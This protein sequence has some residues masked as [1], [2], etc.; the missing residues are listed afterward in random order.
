MIGDIWPMLQETLYMFAYLGIELS[1]LFLAISYVVGVIN[2]Y[3]PARKVQSLMSARSGRGYCFAAALGA[4]TP[5]CSCS[6]I[7][8]LNGLLKAQAG[9]GPIMTFVL[10]SPLL[11]PMIVGLLAATFGVTITAVYSV[12]T[13]MVA[14]LA[15]FLL[16][17][18]GFAKHMRL[19]TSP[20]SCCEQPK[21][22]EDSTP[23]PKSVA[24]VGEPFAMAPLM[25][26][27]C[28][29]EQFDT[30]IEASSCCGAVVS[31][32]KASTWR[33]IAKDSWSQFMHV[34][35]FLLLGVFIGA[36]T[37]GFVP[38]ETITKYAGGGSFW[39]IPIAA[40][41]GIPLYLRAEALIPLA[42]ALAAKGM[43]LGPLMALIIG[44]AGASLTE[45]I[46]L[47]A[48]FGTRIIIAFLAVVLGTAV[49]AGT[50]IQLLGL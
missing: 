43:A 41:I 9:F 34:L 49:L 27:S 42:A 33:Q 15:G 7:P 50:A 37:Y 14:V 44:G 3:L 2:H 4:V 12:V 45:V 11:N 35:P 23:K 10:V 25:R 13:L 38:E 8:M 46:L 5:F 24:S 28:C 47:R 40:V 31:S 20:V 30:T 48:I 32:T 22:M 39:A 36:F 16:H 6:T 19:S 21:N 1:A 17:Q 18:A 29:S 26:S